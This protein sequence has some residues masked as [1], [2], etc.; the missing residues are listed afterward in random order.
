MRIENSMVFFPNFIA[1]P[2]FQLNK[3]SDTDVYKIRLFPIQLLQLKQEERNPLSIFIS[4]KAFFLFKICSAIFP[5]WS[6]CMWCVQ[7]FWMYHPTSFGVDQTTK[8]RM[9]WATIILS[10]FLWQSYGQWASNWSDIF[11]IFKA[12][13]FMTAGDDLTHGVDISRDILFPHCLQTQLW[14]VSSNRWIILRNRSIAILKNG[15]ISQLIDFGVNRLK[16]SFF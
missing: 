7:N 4:F 11:T 1:K 16:D 2:N 14:K 8:D 13:K 15:K 5:L 3:K 9:G 6:M 10:Y 12:T